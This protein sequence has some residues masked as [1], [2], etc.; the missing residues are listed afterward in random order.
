MKK[1]P[2]RKVLIFIIPAVLLMLL[3]IAAAPG[4]IYREQHYRKAM[5]ALRSGDLTTAGKLFSDI[6]KYRDS[7][8]VL[9]CEIPYIQAVNLMDAA[10]A[11]DQNMLEEAGFSSADVNDETTV[12]ML[13]Y[14]SAKEA[15]SSLGDYKDSASRAD[16]CQEG[17]DREVR[18]LREQA[19]EELRQQN[20]EAYDHA[21]K[22][23]ENTSY[24]KALAAFEALGDFAD[25][26]TMAVECRYRKAVS[27]F[28][29]LSRYDVSRIF[30][31]ISMVPEG[32]S[33]FSLPTSEALRLGSSFVDELRVANGRDK[34]DIRL[35]DEPAGNLT[36]LKDALTEMFNA[37]GDYS[38]SASYPARIEDA[39]DYTRDF[40]MLCSTGELQ[41]AQ[42][43]LYEYE[44]EFRDREKWD[45][46]LDLYLPY[47]GSWA[48]Y[49]GD[50]G[51][52]SYTLG[53][54][55]E[56][57]S[58][59]TRVILNKDS[60]ILRLSFGDDQEY[61][62]DLPS[63]FG[64]TMFVNSELYYGIY[65]AGLNSNNGHFVYHRYDDNWNPLSS[66]EF[67][68]SA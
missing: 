67:V 12:P 28:A 18:M 6:P 4:A 13:L 30:T 21:A 53:Q 22:L 8:T 23:L 11:G 17:I 27:L 16:E 35:E 62:I 25:S 60:V 39:T 47:C 32:I 40:F 29:F 9:N 43:W 38:D 63:E 20:Q 5:N 2:Q 56:A 1:L 31:S 54:N 64:E 19:E 37:L 3:L 34:I 48:L 7:E 10:A 15:F 55:F 59:T 57:L 46:L 45:E 33:V 42:S 65:M 58:A 24:S 14:R 49:S 68:R 44:G 52:L 51:L 26:E 41:A 66:C 50:P 36:P 61:T